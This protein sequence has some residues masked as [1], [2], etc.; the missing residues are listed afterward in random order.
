MNKFKQFL[1]LLSAGLVGTV[2]GVVATTDWSNVSA[3][4]PDVIGHEHALQ[5]QETVSA[6]CQSNGTSAH[7]ECPI[8]DLSFQDAS[9]IIRVSPEQLVIEKLP[10]QSSAQYHYDAVAPTCEDNG[11]KEYWICMNGC[12]N[13]F[14]DEDCHQFQTKNS[15]VVHSTNH[16]TVKVP[17]KTAT[18]DSAGNIEYYQCQDCGETFDA[19]MHVLSDVSVVVAHKTDDEHY[20]NY[21]APTC[22][23]DGHLSHYTCINCGGAFSDVECKHAIDEPVLERLEHISDNAYHS[24]E[25]KATCTEN[26]QKEY[27]Q[28]VN[29]CGQKYAEYECKTLMN[30]F[31][32]PSLGGHKYVISFQ[33]EH[34]KTE[35]VRDNH[36]TSQAVYY[37]SCSV[38]GEHNG[39]RAIHSSFASL[40]DGSFDFNYYEESQTGYD[41]VKINSSSLLERDGKYYTEIKIKLPNNY[42]Q[43]SLYN[44]KSV[45]QVSVEDEIM[46]LEICLDQLPMI[47]SKDLV[48]KFDWDGNGNYEQIIIVRIMDK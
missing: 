24:H 31:T 18:C 3:A 46:T 8:C 16:H 9:G 32:I 44:L 22:E 17:A 38:C 41:L 10:H 15:I 23:H 43:S 37:Q 21:L 33:P 42:S 26:G 29:G 7:W 47:Q 20:V 12:G 25:I 5:F 36:G 11:S 34:L 14:A 39:S 30:E 13:Y 6:T 28:C 2:V 1:M 40:V 45:Q 27:W 19:S 35:A 4:E 48:W